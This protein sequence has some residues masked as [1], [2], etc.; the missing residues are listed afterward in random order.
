MRRLLLEAF[1][2]KRKHRCGSKLGL[3]AGLNHGLLR[4]L[5][6]TV[7]DLEAGIL[8]CSDVGLLAVR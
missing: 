8:F 3:T 1:A 7:P 5:F 6:L 4:L 2:R